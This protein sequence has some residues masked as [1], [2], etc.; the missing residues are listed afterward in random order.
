MTLATLF[1]SAAQ[2]N[3]GVFVEGQT[4][5]LA[6]RP[7]VDLRVV[8][9]IGMPPLFSR[10]EGYRE[11]AELPLSE[12]WKGVPVE[13]PRFAIIPSLSGSFN[14][15]SV[16]RAVRPVIRR[17]RDDGFVPDVIDAEFFYPDGPAA[18]RLARSF[19]LPFSVKARGADIHYW[20]ARPNCRR[21][22]LEAAERSA[23]MLAV[24]DSL[25]ADMGKLG[26][27]TAKIRVHYTGVDLDKF[28]PIR[29]Q[30]KHL[31]TVVSLG[32]LIPRKGHDL[33]IKAV[34]KLDGVQ[35]SASPATRS[36]SMSR[37][38]SA[39]TRSSSSPS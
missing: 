12:I 10:H 4:L 5:R 33:V 11:R 8:A 36:S 7:D 31:P 3:H 29:V 26:M 2:P 35:L 16:A 15:W 21:Q 17:L 14:P 23:G 9:P 18:M 19:G 34:A 32:G 24:A 30:P 25:K 22:I 6:A 1:P 20:G 38:K 27:E 28:K 13:R 37:L 39:R